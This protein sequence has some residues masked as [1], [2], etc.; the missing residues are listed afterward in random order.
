MENVKKYFV[1]FFLFFADVIFRTPVS[2]TSASLGVV[3]LRTWP[4][5]QKPRDSG[6]LE[7]PQMQETLFYLNTYGSHLSLVE[8]YWQNSHGLM[9]AE[10]VLT[11]VCE[12]T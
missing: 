4:V 5:L 11:K 8:F 3:T 2:M 7:T 12:T 10:Y 1:S 6:S 9:A